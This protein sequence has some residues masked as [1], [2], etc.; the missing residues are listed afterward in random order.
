MDQNASPQ[1]GMDER[2]APDS[3]SPNESPKQQALVRMGRLADGTSSLESKTPTEGGKGPPLSLP[4]ELIREEVFTVNDV[5]RALRCSKA[6]VCN[7]ISGKVAGVQRLPALKLGRRYLVRLATL[8]QWMGAI[9]DVSA[10]LPAS[11]ET[12]AGRMKGKSHA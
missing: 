4:M 1:I 7:L 5:A 3:L 9:E 8:R 11:S 6:H 12:S 10:I 2:R